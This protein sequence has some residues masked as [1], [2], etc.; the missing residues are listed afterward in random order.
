LGEWQAINRLYFVKKHVELSVPLCYWA[1]VGHVVLN[2]V[3][4]LRHR[5]AGYVVRAWGNGIG[6][7]KCLGGHLD[8]LGGYLKS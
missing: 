5:D 1:S 4:A 2:L 3:Q 6:L 7:I 8:Q